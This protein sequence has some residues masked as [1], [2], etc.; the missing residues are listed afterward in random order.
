MDDS[1]IGTMSVGDIGWMSIGETVHQIEWMSTSMLTST[2]DEV[3]W[4]AGSDVVHLWRHGRQVLALEDFQHS[5]TITKCMHVSNS[6]TYMG[7]K[8]TVAMW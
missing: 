1:D 3:E 5:T 6:S 8:P 7:R 4:A 2:G